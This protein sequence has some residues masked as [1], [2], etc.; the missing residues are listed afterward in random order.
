MRMHR[1]ILATLRRLNDSNLIDTAVIRG[2]GA[3]TYGPGGVT[4]KGQPEVKARTKCLS[5]P[6]TANNDTVATRETRAG[7]Y[8]VML[9]R[10][11]V[12]DETWTIEVIKTETGESKM[13]TINEILG[14]HSLN[15]NMKAYCKEVGA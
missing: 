12:L 11:T 9:P 1:S 2:P 4:V 15:V 13:L 7:L 10:N 5:I 8:V 14:K 3:N 6:L